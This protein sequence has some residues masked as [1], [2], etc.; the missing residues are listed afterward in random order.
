M[1]PIVETHH[2]A[3]MIDVSG[4]F[5]PPSPDAKLVE[6]LQH[7]RYFASADCSG[8][9]MLY[10]DL[11]RFGYVTAGVLHYPAG[12]STIGPYNSYQDD[13]GCQALSG[14]APF[15]QIGQLSVG[16]FVAPFSLSR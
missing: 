13:D 16:A 11:T 12:P 8:T 5:V 4:D 2:G 3:G 10:L 9:P 14:T 7:R 6:Q 1:A 15:A